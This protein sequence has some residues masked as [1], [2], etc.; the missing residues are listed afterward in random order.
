M[1]EYCIDTSYGTEFLELLYIGMYD[2]AIR[3][4]V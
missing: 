2:S 1:Y 4:I 3:P